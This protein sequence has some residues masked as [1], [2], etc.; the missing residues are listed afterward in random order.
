[1]LVIDPFKRNHLICFACHSSP[2][3]KHTHL[4]GASNS[5]GNTNKPAF[6]FKFSCFVVK[7]QIVSVICFL[8]VFQSYRSM[9]HRRAGKSE[10]GLCFPFSMPFKSSQSHNHI[11]TFVFTPRGICERRKGKNILDG[12]CWKEAV[13]S[14][15]VCGWRRG[16]DVGFLSLCWPDGDFSV[17]SDD[18]V[19]SCSRWS[20]RSAS[21][22]CGQNRLPTLPLLAP[23]VPTRAPASL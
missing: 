2:R 17:D 4:R 16:G 7:T 15:A 13:M 20:L 9:F 23:P 21:A 8:C 22:S 6:C 11:F 3:R 1:M 19:S 10:R 5:A 14:T 12:R 18:L